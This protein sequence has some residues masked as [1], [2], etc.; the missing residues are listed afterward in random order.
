M[1]DDSILKATPTESDRD[2]DEYQE[3][4]CD[5]LSRT[6]SVYS[7]DS[8]SHHD[9]PIFALDRFGVSDFLD[10]FAS[11]K[12]RSQRS[13][14][15]KSISKRY[16]DSMIKRTQKLKALTKSQ[17]H[18]IRSQEEKLDHIYK[19]FLKSV[20]KLDNRLS[21]AT[22]VSNTEKISFALSLYNIFFGGYVIGR[23]PD[24]FHV[25][26]SVE[27]AF[28]MPIRFYTYKKKLYHFFLADLCYFVN[29]LSLLFIWVFPSSENLFISCYA[30]TFGTLAWAVVTWRNSLVLHSI[31]KIT[32]SFIH[33]LPPTTFHVITHVISPVYK[34]ERF[35]GA[36]KV[37]QWK[38]VYG[39][40]W[41]S[42]YYFVWQLSYHYFITI[43]KKDKIK[44][45]QVTSFSWLQKSYADNVLGKIV[46]SLPNEYL[47]IAAFSFIQFGYQL[48]TMLLCPIWYKYRHLSS[49]FLTFIFMTA[50]YNGAT[51]YIDHFG[52]KLE[53]EVIN[54]Q[55]EV[56]RLRMNISEVNRS[57]GVSTPESQEIDNINATVGDS[58][59]I[60]TTNST[61]D[62]GSGD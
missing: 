21:T 47:Q 40:I 22:A 43:R 35:P 24:W 28:L 25:M 30:L 61:S 4:D 42:V 29:L 2:L 62:P 41:T 10:L 8:N 51:Y 23:H 36:N 60:G 57:S 56:V 52:K 12:E 20:E 58:S 55:E 13:L 59:E 27:L 50:S 14:Q 26:Y 32:S 6:T 49:L 33:I 7:L 19:G 53:K 34:A 37:V 31:D 1:S 16:K 44:A 18:L 5:Q 54:L 46:N 3:D 45:G 38:F 9:E 11:K 48:L 17:R 39:L 15:L